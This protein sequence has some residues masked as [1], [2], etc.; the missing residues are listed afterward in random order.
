MMKRLTILL[1]ALLAMVSCT[2]K[3]QNRF[4]H[5]DGTQFILD[6][7]PYY[8]IGANYWAGP[9]LGS[10]GKGG[11]RERLA[12]DLD[13]LKAAGV[14]NLRVLA[15]AD[16]PGENNRSI[17]PFL[18][19]APGVLDE[20]LLTGLDYFMA[21]IAKRDMKAILYLNNDCP[22]SGGYIYYVKQVT[23]QE[24]PNFWT[25]DQGYKEFSSKFI[26]MR[27]CQELYFDFLKTMVSRTNSI[28]G[29][30]YKDD[31]ALFAWQISNEPRAMVDSLHPQ[32][33]AFMHESAELIRSIDSNHMISTGCEGQQGC[34]SDPSEYETI[35]ADPLVDYLT[36]HIWPDNWGFKDLYGDS[37]DQLQNHIDVARKL[38]KPLVVEEFGLIRDGH[39]YDPSVPTT[40]RDEYYEW[41]FSKVVKSAKEGDLL[42]G[43]NFWA[44][45]GAGRAADDS[46][47]EEGDDLLGDPPFE[48]QGQFSVFDCDTTTLNIVK[49]NNELITG[50]KN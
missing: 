1:S 42:A 35:H 24:S 23:G 28:T 38:N 11:D 2:T 46:V 15:G 4:V 25:D 41:L 29:V 32:F 16:A 40:H 26:A 19:K 47:W 21:E 33:I 13:V 34:E 3:V 49:K 18:Q 50:K 17:I 44:F 37:Q 27:E 14:N 9:V 45:A 7:Q 6:G 36:F 39:E 12:H 20:D 30:A 48:P 43:A 10:P 31:P 22:W 8:Y 5:T